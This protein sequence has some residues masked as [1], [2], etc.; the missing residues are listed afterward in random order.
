MDVLEL[1]AWPCDIGECVV[2]GVRCCRELVADGGG[3]QLG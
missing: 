2:S 3:A 1:Q